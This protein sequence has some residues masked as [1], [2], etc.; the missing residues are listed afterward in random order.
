MTKPRVYTGWLRLENGVEMLGNWVREDEI[1]TA[2]PPGELS[3]GTAVT[4]LEPFFSE[5][6]RDGW[7]IENIDEPRPK[8]YRI[9]HQNGSL[10]DVL[11]ECIAEN[12]GD[13]R[14]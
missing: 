12:R 9:R 10:L 5:T 2:E 6:P 8:K 4:L 14:G 7:V 13:E 3:A 1:P 11:P